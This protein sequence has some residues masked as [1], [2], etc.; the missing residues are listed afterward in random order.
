EKPTARR[1]H[2]LPGPS[3]TRFVGSSFPPCGGGAGPEGAGRGGARWIWPVARKRRVG[4]QLEPRQNEGGCR[5]RSEAG[6]AAVSRERPSS[7]DPGG[8]SASRRAARAMARAGMERWR[9]RLALVTGASG[10]IGAAVA[11]A[12]VQQGLKVVGCARTVGNIEE[13]AAECRSA[14]YPGTLIPYRCDLSSEEDIL[15]M[16]SAVR[17]QHS[18][19][20]ICINNA[21]LARP[22]TLL[23][24][25]TRGWRDMFSVNVLA[26]SICTR[27]AYHMSGHR[28]LPQS[29]THFYSATKYAVTA[30]T[31]GLRQELREAQT[32]I[33][34]TCISP[35]V[36]ETQFAFKL[37][38]KDPEKAAAI[39]E[40][41]KCLKPEDVAEAVIYVLSTPPHVQMQQGPLTV[42]L[43]SAVRGA[44]WRCSGRLLM[45]HFS[46]AARRE[47]R[48]GGEELRRLLLDDLPPN[49]RSAGGLEVLFGLSPCLLALRAARRRVARL[50]LQ[51]GRS[52]LQG[53]RAEL[54]RVAEARDIPVLRPSRQKLDA[55]CRY[56]VHQ[57]VCMEVSPLQPRPWTE[58]GEARP[59]DDS[60][61][62]W[63]VL[64]GLQD[65]R[66]LGAVL[67]SAHFLGASAG[68]MEV[69]D[70]FF[71]DDLAAFLQAKAQQGWL[72][73]GTVGCPEPEIAPSSEIPITSCLD[74][75]WKQPTLLVL[76][77]EGSGLSREVQASCRL[78]LTILP[79]RQLP[80]GLESLNPEEEFPCRGEERAAS[81]RPPR[82]LSHIRRAQS[83]SAPRTASPVTRQSVHLLEGTDEPD[84][85]PLIP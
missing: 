48:P 43:L 80:P 61:Q 24:G 33:R 17:S 73:A 36:V 47:Q 72:V 55:L 52:G 20:D 25:S 4:P 66:N 1:D 58:V 67:R 9:D 83:G 28:V 78:L 22:D 8:S 54:L 6:W 35:G 14:G 62:L 85:R 64:E 40:H 77:N 2:E 31:E 26:L 30:L 50:L 82:T 23:S 59:G 45:R 44:T 76:G 81:P 65:P 68:A 21:G 51:A 29:M 74:F 75:L 53:E 18:G 56:H 42:A 49:P 16:F 5:R 19:V 69:M 3:R 27:E 37:H 84:P 79:G 41:I 70:V 71:T 63:L 15:S 12:L 13:L 60:Q 11:R 38:D 32:H 7:C 34:A 10:G 57:G 39:Y 46:L